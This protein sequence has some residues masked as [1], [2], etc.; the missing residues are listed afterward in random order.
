M[1]LVTIFKKLFKLFKS[2]GFKS[3]MKLVA[4]IA[5]LVISEVQWVADI[6]SNKTDNEVLEWAKTVLPGLQA[7]TVT[8]VTPEI[9]ESLLRTAARTIARKG[10]PDLSE[11]SDRII[12]AA[13][14]VA[15]VA[16]RSQP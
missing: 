16:Y 2:E 10:R 11:F 4:E 9:R 14:Q 6:T 13:V 5:P 7:L 8:D 1:F 15:Y 3:D 12:D